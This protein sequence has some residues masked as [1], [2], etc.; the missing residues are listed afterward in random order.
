LVEPCVLI[1]SKPGDFILDP[2]FGSG[3][4]GVVCVQYKRRYVGLELNPDYVAIAANRLGI[5]EDNIIK[6]AV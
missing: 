3:T 1:S 4:V 2:F 5:A 6:V